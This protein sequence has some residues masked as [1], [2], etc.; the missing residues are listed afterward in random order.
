MI[1]LGIDPGIAC[2]GWA[3]LKSPKLK[4]QCSNLKTVDYGC[5]TTD[6]K[7]KTGERLEK[8]YRELEKIIKKYKPNVISL[9]KIFFAKNAK[10]ALIIGEVNGVI[11]LL[12][13]KKKIRVKEFTPLQVK[14][15]LTGYGRADKKQIQKMV[16]N[17]LKLKNIPRPDDAADALAIAICC[18]K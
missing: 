18:L 7:L 8:I 9:E 3:I 6:R 12:A 17:I 14:I 13:S 15:S 1:I 2:L 10:T 11:L 4:A 5:I 16:K